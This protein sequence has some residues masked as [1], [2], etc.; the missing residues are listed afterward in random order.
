MNHSLSNRHKVFTH[1][2]VAFSGSIPHGTMGSEV[3]DIPTPQC[4]SDSSA[5][6]D[7]WLQ[8]STG[9]GALGLY[10]ENEQK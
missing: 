4:D 1:V 3:E 5:I 6:Y 2:S 9:L 10:Y 8:A 7:S